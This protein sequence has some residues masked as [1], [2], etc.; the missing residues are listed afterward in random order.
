[1]MNFDEEY[2]RTTQK[3]ADTV[4]EYA[5]QFVARGYLDDYE[6]AASDVAGAYLSKE[7]DDEMYKLILKEV[8]WRSG[9]I[10][11]IGKKV[12]LALCGVLI[13]FCGAITM[14]V[15]L[16]GELREMLL[17]ALKG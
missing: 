11:R 6:K 12:L 1:M 15:L 14:Y 13:V 3:M 4:M 2:N 9:R 7:F 8:K 10:W 16:N 17:A 5:S